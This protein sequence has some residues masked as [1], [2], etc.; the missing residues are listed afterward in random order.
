[1][2]IAKFGE[3]LFY[4]TEEVGISEEVIKMI[5]ENLDIKDYTGPWE[6]PP[7]QK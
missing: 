6:M 1:M 4:H 3:I 7:S 5:A 2:T